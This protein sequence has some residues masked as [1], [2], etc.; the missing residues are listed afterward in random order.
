[1]NKTPEVDQDKGND[2]P[3]STKFAEE[4]DHASSKASSD[5][6]SGLDDDG[7]TF[8]GLSDTKICAVVDASLK[9]TGFHLGKQISGKYDLKLTKN[10]EPIHEP[11]WLNKWPAFVSG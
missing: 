3:A 4:Y 2:Q 11:T 10:A 5:D 7:S 9:D 1:M 8:N 6:E